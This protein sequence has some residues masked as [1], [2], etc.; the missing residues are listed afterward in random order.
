MKVLLTCNHV[1]KENLIKNN[2][3]ITFKHKDTIKNLK[4]NEKRFVCT[5]EE[6]DYTCVQILN[7]DKLYDFFKIDKNI[8]KNPNKIYKKELF[9]IY[10]CPKGNYVSLSEGKIELFRS[11]G[12]N[13]A[14]YFY[15]WRFFWWFIN[16]IKKYKCFCYS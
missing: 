7:D 4:I 13:L 15:L 14:L 11:Y 2:S 8:N 1:L 16:F 10:Q 6:L 9:A 3:A 12:L 5:N